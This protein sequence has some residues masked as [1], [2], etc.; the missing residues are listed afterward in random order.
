MTR[1]F[2]G[3]D[4]LAHDAGY[5]F[6]ESPAR[7]DRI[8]AGFDSSWDVAEVSEHPRLAEVL[9]TVHEPCY[10]EIFR[11][12]VERGDGLLGSSDNPLTT[13]TWRSAVSAASAA[14]A[15]ADWVAGGNGKA[16]AAV[17]PP[18]HHAESRLA[19]GFCYLNNVAVLVEHLIRNHGLQKIAIFDFDVHHGNGT[20]EIFYERS[21]VLFASMH[22]WPFYPGTGAESE[23]GRGP[24]EDKTVNVALAAGTGD[25]EFL[26]AMRD[27]IIP[28]LAS[29]QPEALVV[30][31]GFDAWRGDPLG[32]LKLSRAAYAEIGE[33]LREFADRVCDG[34]LISVL[35]GGYD[36]AALSGLVRSYLRGR[37]Q[38]D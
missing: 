27:S 16:F 12:A 32:G 38:S 19:M 34:R 26:R 10:L 4:C 9:E 37:V 33:T 2:T 1:I 17:R 31:A 22:Q 7:L 20:Q 35:E 23:T 28:A 13:E 8:L 25:R 11:R 29:H 24:G 6:P 14:M 3:I 36:L 15:A 18:G 30:S 21:D 5:G